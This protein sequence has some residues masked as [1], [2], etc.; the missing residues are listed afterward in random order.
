MIA[1]T[2]ELERLVAMAE[3]DYVERNCIPANNIPP[4]IDT[5]L[6]DADLC[7][8]LRGSLLRVPLA[9]GA[10]K[11]YAVPAVGTVFSRDGTK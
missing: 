7:A 9:A 2:K 5:T 3:K 4:A 1:H 11:Y 6:S 8:R 10:P